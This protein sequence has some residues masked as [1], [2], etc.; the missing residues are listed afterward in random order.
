MIWWLAFVKL[1]KCSVSMHLG[2]FVV[3]HTPVYAD[4]AG[5]T[6][7]TAL[8]VSQLLDTPIFFKCSRSVFNEEF[9]ICFCNFPDWLFKTVEGP[10]CRDLQNRITVYQ[11]TKADRSGLWWRASGRWMTGTFTTVPP[12]HTPN[13]WTFRCPYA[14]HLI[15]FF[16]QKVHAHQIF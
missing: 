11:D 14:D 3:L 1:L 5:G 15:L 6:G 16:G 13:F 7:D 2:S 10:F 12:S 8:M 9:K 4:R